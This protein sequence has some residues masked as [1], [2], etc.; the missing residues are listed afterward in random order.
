M[1]YA[2]KIL[3]Q[4]QTR[5]DPTVEHFFDLDKKMHYILNKK[6]LSKS[7]KMKQYQ[8]ILN[9]YLVADN[10]IT[11][12]NSFVS[13]NN[14]FENIKTP[15]KQETTSIRR[16]SSHSSGFPHDETSDKNIKPIIRSSTQSSGFQNDDN[17]YNETWSINEPYTLDSEK[18]T[19]G[20][21]ASQIF[22]TKTHKDSDCFMNE[23]ETLDTGKKG[24]GKSISQLF[25]T[26]T[27]KASDCIKNWAKF[28]YNEES[29][30]LFRLS[31]RN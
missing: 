18:K 29:Q 5:P 20:K 6:G 8:Q 19:I 14:S 15:D 9:R 24:I 2:R 10:I 4:P 23:A 13:P 21:S 16:S 17:S 22:T 25:K 3:V 30:L 26:K 27:H 7:E 12:N 31:S 11:R 28:W 1:K